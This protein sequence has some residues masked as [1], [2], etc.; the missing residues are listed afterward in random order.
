MKKEW[1]KKRGKK[2]SKKGSKKVPV[3]KEVRY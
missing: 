3:I 2:I 1:K